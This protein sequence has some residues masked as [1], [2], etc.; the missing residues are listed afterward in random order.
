MAERHAVRHASEELCSVISCG[1]RSVRSVPARDAIG[2]AKMSI[3]PDNGG[4]AHL[5]K[6]HYKDFKKTTRSERELDR[7]TW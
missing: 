5:C 2:K 6:K 1:E 7:L 3:K 4:R